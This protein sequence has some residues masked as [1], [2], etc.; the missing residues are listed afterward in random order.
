MIDEQLARENILDHARYPRNYG[1]MESPDAR[2]EGRNPLCG[3]ELAVDLQIEDGRIGAV[4]FHGHG[5]SISKASLSMLSEE[6]EG[7]PVEEVAS[8]D[9]SAVMDLLGIPLSP[10]RLKCALL[11]LGVV[12]V[13]LNRHS[14]TPLPADWPGTNEITWQ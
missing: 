1:E 2:A 6:I 4:R 13:A 3:D 14:G 7:R 11:G 12:K 10:I 8:M 5:C 9:R